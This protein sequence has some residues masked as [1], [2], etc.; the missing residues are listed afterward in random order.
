MKHEADGLY[1]VTADMLELEGACEGSVRA[2]RK[3]ERNGRVLI[4]LDAVTKYARAKSSGHLE[5][6]LE[7]MAKAG[8]FSMEE[9]W[10]FPGWPTPEQFMDKLAERARRERKLK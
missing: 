8:Y 6:A 7:Y 1:Y 9:Y 10:E 2:V 5:T 4:T 3:R